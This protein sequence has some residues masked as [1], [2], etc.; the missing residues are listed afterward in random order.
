MLKLLTA[1]A[2]ARI[3]V[4]FPSVDAKLNDLIIQTSIKDFDIFKTELKKYLKVLN[5]IK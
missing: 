1:R 3:K 5:E 2:R 4:G